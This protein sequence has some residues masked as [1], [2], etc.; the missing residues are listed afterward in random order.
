MDHPVAEPASMIWSG[1][2]CVVLIT[3][4]LMLAR[5]LLLDQPDME[6]VFDAAALFILHGNARN[7]DVLNAA[8]L[9][10]QKKLAKRHFTCIW[11]K[12]R[13]NGFRD[14]KKIF[15]GRRLELGNDEHRGSL[16]STMQRF[17]R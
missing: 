17:R 13:K 3:I 16:E 15:R 14:R 11:G 6:T 7:L 4:S 1:V 5:M 10:M 2:E 8:K 12:V 9:V